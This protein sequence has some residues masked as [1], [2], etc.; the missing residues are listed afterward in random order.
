M[1]PRAA[2][3][4]LSGVSQTVTHTNIE[5][6]FTG[7]DG[8]LRHGWEG[9]QADTA[10]ARGAVS[11][12]TAGVSNLGLNVIH[13]IVLANLLPTQEIGVLTGANILIAGYATVV[14]LALPQAVLKY[15]SDYA[16]RHYVYAI[17]RLVWLALRVTFATATPVAVLMYV[18]AGPLAAALFG[19]ETQVLVIQLAAIDAW[20]FVVSQVLLALLFGLNR[21]PKASGILIVGAVLRFAIAVGLVIAGLRLPGAFQGYVIGDAAL[22]TLTL[23]ATRRSLLTVPHASDPPIPTM[24]LLSYSLPLVVAGLVIFAITQLDKI[25]IW[26][27][28]ILGTGQPPALSGLAI[29]NI[30]AAASVYVLGGASIAAYAPNAVTVALI[31]SLSPLSDQEAREEF[32]KLAKKYTRYVSLVAIPTAFGL[33][34]LSSPLVLLFGPQY[35]RA[36]LPAAIMALAV[37][38][39]AVSAVY[40]SQLMAR[41]KTGAIMYA[42]LVGLLAFFAALTILVPLLEFEGA[43]WARAI[44]TVVSAVT[45]ALYVYREGVFVFDRR[46]FGSALV[47][48]AIMG[49]LLFTLTTLIGGYRLQLAALPVL[50]PLGVT[51]YFLALRFLRAFTLDDFDFLVRLLPARLRAV[52]SFLAKLAGVRAEQ[53][54][55]RVQA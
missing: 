16:A 38:V 27:Y 44:M 30:A 31:P 4:Y 37:G 32:V 35:L 23:Y 39:T 45:L 10:V 1:G 26:F 8:E 15:V 34:A 22:L 25:Y 28:P 18:Y 40:V 2:R 11:L 36:A 29:Y 21:I 51:V 41:R 5:R 50:V 7:T 9:L 48:S 54:A 52:V 12:Y 6:L 43:A 33:A 13:L 3:F 24:K 55:T 47:A 53:A 17:G 14:G 19:S 49:L 42:N 46:A 20:L